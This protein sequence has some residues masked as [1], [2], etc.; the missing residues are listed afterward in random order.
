[1][2]GS[3]DDSLEAQMTEMIEGVKPGCRAGEARGEGAEMEGQVDAEGKEH[4]GR[5][6]GTE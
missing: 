5:G 4:R 2:P 1:M 6:R 3:G